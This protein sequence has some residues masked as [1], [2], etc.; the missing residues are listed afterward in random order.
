M[1]RGV[2]AIPDLPGKLVNAGGGLISGALERS[3]AIAPETAGLMRDAIPMAS[4][5]GKWRSY[6]RFARSATGGA[7]DYQGKT[8]AGKYAGTVGE[9][10]P[11]AALTGGVGAIPQFA[12]APALLRNLRGK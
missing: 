9:F 4:P 12:V 1:G 8:A 6:K 2:A 5:F 11:G 10:V 3:G 7:S